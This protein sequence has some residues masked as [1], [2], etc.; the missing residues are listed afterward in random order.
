MTSI[1]W[2]IKDGAIIISTEAGRMFRPL[3]IVDID[4]NN[5]RSLRIMNILKKLNI[6]WE[7][8]SKNK[9]F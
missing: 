7:E 5:N 4:K 6:T 8:F 1:V 9:T 3:L 2:N